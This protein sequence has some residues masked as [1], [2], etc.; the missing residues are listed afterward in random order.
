MSESVSISRRDVL[1]ITAGVGLGAAFGLG[2]SRE[3]FW[4]AGLHRVSETRVQMGTLVNITVVHPDNAGAHEMIDSAFLEMERLEAVLSRYRPDSAVGRLN[5]A[6]LLERAPSPLIEVIEL[7]LEVSRRSSG[8]FDVTVAP[9]VELYGS[10]FDRQGRPPTDR[11]IDETLSYVGHDGL[12]VTG[13]TVTL[14]DRRMA[15]SLD[16]VAK[17]FVVDRVVD[18][19]SAKGAQRVLVD[20]GG[21]MASNRSSGRDEAWTIGIQHPRRTEATIGRVQLIGGGVATSGDYFRSFTPDHRHHDILDPR[22]GRPAQELSSASLLASSA[23]IADALSTA[24]LVL[25]PVDGIDFIDGFQGAE[26]ILVSKD[27]SQLL[28]KGMGKRLG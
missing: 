4:R 19:L 16:G 6:G 13:S 25:G 10:T 23:M 5:A 20:A 21:D 1:R 24:A 8:A 17:G 28:S 12:V 15:I 22:T 11:E 3:A 18:Q 2:V 14:A 9:L 26:G 7:A 27:G